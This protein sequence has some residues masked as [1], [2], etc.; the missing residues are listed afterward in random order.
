MRVCPDAESEALIWRLTAVPTVPVW[1]PGL[2]TVTVLPPGLVTIA[3]LASQD[4]L[5]LLPSL[6]QMV[7][8]AY[9]PVPVVR[10]KLPPEVPG[11]IH[12]Q[13]SPTS[14]PLELVQPPAG[15]WSVMVSLYSWPSTIVTPS[16]VPLLLTKSWPQE[17]PASVMYG[18]LVNAMSP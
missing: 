10:S 14:E 1:L 2:V 5:P 6:P 15:F 7:W 4:P 8:T 9:V 18:R 12:A 16:S 13:T 11:V 17:V 3:W